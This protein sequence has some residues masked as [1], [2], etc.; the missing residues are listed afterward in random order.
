MGH[1]RQCTKC[2]NAADSSQPGRCKP[3][4]AAYTREREA[5]ILEKFKGVTEGVKRCSKCRETKALSEFR[6]DG[7]WKD[8]RY[9]Y[10]HPCRR[11]WQRAYYR[12]HQEQMK[13]AARRSWSKH[14]DRRLPEKYGM[15][16]DAYA[17]MWKNQ[18][19]VCAICEG[20][21]G[22]RS[23]RLHIDHDH[24]TEALRELLCNRCNLVLGNIQ[25]DVAML[26]KLIAYIKKH[27]EKQRKA[28]GES[29]LIQF[30]GTVG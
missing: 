26:E 1:T 20:L 7:N 14:K 5:K 10:C 23:G 24:Q 2:G 19:G 21:P 4:C 13:A 29:N 18:R 3:C 6:S 12:R 27:Q 25:D 15:T 30:P 17:V 9:P 8:G 28:K 22:G 11:E 16:P